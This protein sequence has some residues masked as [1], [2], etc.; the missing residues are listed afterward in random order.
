MNSR[1]ERARERFATSVRRRTTRAIGLGIVLVI[2]VVAVDSCGIPDDD[3][4][5]EI[6]PAL[7]Q[8]ITDQP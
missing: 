2:T 4:P 3:A 5:R 7:L 6:D 1:I 8:N